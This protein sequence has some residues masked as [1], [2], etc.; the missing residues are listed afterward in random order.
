MLGDF[1]IYYEVLWINT[2]FLLDLLHFNFF[3]WIYWIIQVCRFNL[4]NGD[5]NGD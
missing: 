2:V 4:L 3:C 1:T 5:A